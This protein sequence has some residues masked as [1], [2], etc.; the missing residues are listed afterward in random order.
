MKIASLDWDTQ[1]FGFKVGLYKMTQPK[2]FSLNELRTEAKKDGFRLVYIQTSDK[3]DDSSLFFDEKII[4]FKAKAVNSIQH[5]AHSNVF[6]YALDYIEPEVYD[7]A[8]I[9]GE[10]SRYNLDKEFPHECF[11]ALYRKWIENSVFTDY[12]TNVLVYK[13]VE[14]PVG[15]LTYKNTKDNSTIGLISVHPDYQHL[16]IG[17]TLINH[18]QSLL[19]PQIESLEVATQGINQKAI[20]F[21]QKNGY[22]IK[23]KTYIYHLWIQ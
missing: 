2:Q 22:N 8:I 13:V 3:I 18:Y 5:T 10:Y 9:S 11:Q 6:T 15:L 12:A 7:L 4:L 1:N 19:C 16:G 23:S 21:Y 14:K 17:T 20:T